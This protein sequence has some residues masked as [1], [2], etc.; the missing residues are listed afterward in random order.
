MLSDTIYQPGWP[1]YQLGNSLDVKIIFED[2]FLI[3]VWFRYGLYVIRSTGSPP[4][5]TA[6][7]LFDLDLDAA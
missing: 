2:Q 4:C 6:F 7:L 1:Q 5:T 3:A